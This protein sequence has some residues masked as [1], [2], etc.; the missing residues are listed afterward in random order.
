MPS[1]R[2]IRARS[3]ETKRRYETSSEAEATAA[4][5]REESGEL[6]LDIYPCRFCNG[7]HIGHVQPKKKPL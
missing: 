3:C 7:W 6:D 5:R 4:H 2:R 1:R